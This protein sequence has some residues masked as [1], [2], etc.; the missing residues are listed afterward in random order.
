MESLSILPKRQKNNFQFVLLWQIWLTLNATCDKSVKFWP[1]CMH[2]G[3]WKWKS[4]LIF[5]M[6]LIIACRKTA[7]TLNVN[8]NHPPR[9]N[10]RT[11]KGG[12][13]LALPRINDQD[14]GFATPRALSFLSNTRIHKF[15]WPTAC[16]LKSAAWEVKQEKDYHR[17]R[18]HKEL[19][20][21]KLRLK[22]YSA[23]PNLTTVSNCTNDSWCVY[24]RKLPTIVF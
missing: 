17:F 5:I 7:E 18:V 23:L 10:W 3:V 6:H 4:V 22:I 14:Q 12:L 9:E 11:L 20:K 2:L 21:H 1:W 16:I 15:K 8:R 13:R 19:L 24:L